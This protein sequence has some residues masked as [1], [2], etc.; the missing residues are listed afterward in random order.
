MPLDVEG[1]IEEGI[2]S[3]KMKEKKAKW[4]NWKTIALK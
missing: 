2:I 1:Y 4:I 3:K